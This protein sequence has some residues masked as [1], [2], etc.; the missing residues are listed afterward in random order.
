MLGC[1]FKVFPAGVAFWFVKIHVFAC[2]DMSHQNELK[3]RLKELENEQLINAGTLVELT[4]VYMHA[5]V[6]IN[7]PENTKYKL[8]IS[9]CA[10][11]CAQKKISC[12]EG[13]HVPNQHQ[14][15]PQGNS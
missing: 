2:R 10:M 14:S 8:Q 1:A 7:G 13:I 6:A 9:S 5:S 3:L 12:E 4:K 11:S 15:T